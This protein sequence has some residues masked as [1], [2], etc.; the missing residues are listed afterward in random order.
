[1][2]KMAMWLLI[3]N[4]SR[5]VEV[6]LAGSGL[7]LK[8]QIFRRTSVMFLLM[9]M[10]NV[11]RGL[12]HHRNRLQVDSER[13]GSLMIV[14]GRLDLVLPMFLRHDLLA[15]NVQMALPLPLAVLVGTLVHAQGLG[16]GR[17]PKM[18]LL[19]VAPLRLPVIH[20]GRLS[21]GVDPL[22]L[23]VCVGMLLP[24][25]SGQSNGTLDGLLPIGVPDGVVSLLALRD[26]VVLLGSDNVF[27]TQHKL[28]VTVL[29]NIALNLF[30]LHLPMMIR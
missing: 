29:V 25:G 26:P 3:Y 7:S 16:L 8:L 2:I 13:H 14:G 15:D 18:R 11:H 10:N 4:M 28:P 24:Y 22:L 9:T 30:L 1:M 23:P 17:L 12:H 5:P 27:V 21:G 20:A 6:P 19:L